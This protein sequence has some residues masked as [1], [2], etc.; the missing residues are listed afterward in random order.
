MIKLIY[1][2]ISSMCVVSEATR[3]SLRGCKFP[4]FHD[5]VCPQNPYFG[6]A[7]TLYNFP[8]QLKNL[9]IPAKLC[10]CFCSFIETCHICIGIIS[11]NNT[12]DYC[13]LSH[14]CII[15]LQLQKQLSTYEFTRLAKIKV[16]KKIEAQIFSKV[17]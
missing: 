13:A 9:L 8:P 5:G 6:Y 15:T 10:G 4:N 14:C 16:N 1:S 3:N 7:T 11:M 17:S 2:N 12:V